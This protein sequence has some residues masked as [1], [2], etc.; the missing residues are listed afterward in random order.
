MPSNAN[1][2]REIDAR[3]AQLFLD[4]EVIEHTNRLQRVIHQPIKHFANPVYTVEAPWEGNGIVYLGGVYIDPEDSLWKAWYASLYPP[5][6]PEIIYAVC[7]IVSDDGIH[8]RRPELDVFIG[9]NGEKT[10]IVLELGPDTGGTGAPSIMYEPENDPEPW[11]MF[12]STCPKGNWRYKGYLLRS[13][14][15]VHWR[16]VQE[17]HNGLDHG[18]G[19]RCTAMLGPDPAFPYVMMSRSEAECRQWNLVRPSHRVA[20]NESAVDESDKHVMVVYPDLEDPPGG[21]IYHAY[22]FRYESTYVGLFQWYWETN[23]P[24]AEMELIT[25]RDTVHWERINPRKPFL[26]CGPHGSVSGAFDARATDTALSPPIRFGGLVDVPSQ[27]NGRETLWFYYWG[28]PAMHGNRH[29]TWGRGLGMAQLRIDGFCSLRANRFP[30]MLFT[31][32]M[33]WPG[34]KLQVN[35]SVLGG[36][37]GGHVRTEVLDENLA[38]IEGMTRADSDMLAGDGIR[39]DQSWGGDENRIAALKGKRIRLK[40]HLENVDLYSFCSSEK[41]EQSN[42]SYK[43][44]KADEVYKEKE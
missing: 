6:Y 16:W 7:M 28:G 38:P 8:W 18:M 40:F 30:G 25:S 13:S 9:H 43:L 27:K 17:R 32:P 33:V 2:Q 3:L 36:G 12:I 42:I 26:P 15:G 37:G 20:A 34:G 5:E 41:P 10:N 39:L 44:D 35:A 14:D 22:G 23:D 19:D 31:R 11:T 29:L 24:Y 4:D 1:H 21:Q